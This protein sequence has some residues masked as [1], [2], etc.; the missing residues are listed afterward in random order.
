M[1]TRYRRRRIEIR[2]KESLMQ[3]HLQFGYGMM[4]HCRSLVSSWGG[5]TAI[6]S[7]RDLDDE[8]LERLAKSIN[9]LPHGR[10]LLDPQFY[11]PHADHE[12]LC[13]HAYWPD[14]YETGV[15]FQGAA[16]TELLRKLLELNVRLGCAEFILPGLL[17]TSVD[18]DW[19]AIQRTIIEESQAKAKQLPLMATIALSA[20]AVKDE[21]QIALLLEAT[22]EWNVQGYYVVC[23]HPNGQYLVTEPNWIANVIDLAA[24]LRLGGAKVSLG[25]CNHQMLIAAI[26]KVGAIASGTW[27]N[28]RSFPPEKFKAKYDDEIKQRA[29]WYY[30]AQALSEYKIP[31]LDIANRQNVLSLMAPP[32]ELDG[33]FAAALFSGAQPTSVPFS[34]QS[35]FRHYLHCLRG[36]CAN[37]TGSSFDDT[38]GIHERLLDDAE[39]LLQRLAPSGIRGQLRDFGEIVDVNRAALELF[40]T[41]RGAVMRRRWPAL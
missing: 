12:R 16:L 40:K 8:Q 31:F 20:E 21:A 2:G 17:A 24:G 37:A 18:D 3:L 30:C 5:G 11:V 22:A 19:L 6:L 10:C 13:A 39:T 35:A 34:E 33:G 26:A 29:T 32:A 28:V 14:E 7:P 15:F 9:A 36:Q 4:E 38:I 25:Y 41:L 27:M 1:G 23:E